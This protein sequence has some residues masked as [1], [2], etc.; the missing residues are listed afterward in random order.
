MP[1]RDGEPFGLALWRGTLW[2]GMAD[3]RLLGYDPRTGAKQ[4]DK[5][6]PLREPDGLKIAA[7]VIVVPVSG[8]AA[9]LV[10]GALGRIDPC[11]ARVVWRARLP[12]S[13][14]APAGAPQLLATAR[15]LIWVRSSGRGPERLVALDPESGRI[16]TSLRLTDFGGTG[17]VAVDGELWLPT[18]GGEVLIVRP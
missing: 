13:P 16:V 14:E 5:Q 18:A 3:G 9:R 4:S 7:G 15:G 2:V 12:A 8:G 11:A 10:P 1:R 6:L 17:V